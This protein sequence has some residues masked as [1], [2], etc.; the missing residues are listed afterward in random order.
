VTSLVCPTGSGTALAARRLLEAI[1]SGD[2]ARLERELSRAAVGP[3]V[4]EAALSEGFERRELLEAVTEQMRGGLRRMRR[5]S[6]RRLD[7]A[8]VQLRLLRHLAAGRG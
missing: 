4:V 3:G 1:E 2:V 5:G 6:S 7:G 8:R